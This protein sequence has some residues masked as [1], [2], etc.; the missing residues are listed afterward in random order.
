MR[1]PQEPFLIR[2]E[3]KEVAN[4]GLNLIRIPM[5]TGKVDTLE[6]KR[7]IEELAKNASQERYYVHG[8]GESDR[9]SLFINLVNRFHPVVKASITPD[10]ASNAITSAS[11]PVKPRIFPDK[12]GIKLERGTTIQVD[13]HVIVS[14]KPTLDELKEYFLNTPNQIVN[15]PVRTVVSLNQ[16]ENAAESREMIA[17]LKANHIAY[18]NMP[19]QLDPYDPEAV[20]KIVNKIK[21]LA[22]A[23]LVYS[24]YMPPQSTATAVFMTSWLTRLPA[25]PNN[26][27][28]SVPMQ[29]GEVKILAPNVA[30]GPRPNA[31]EFKDYLADKGIR[32]IAYVG[33]CEFE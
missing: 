22:N 13:N 7:Q 9:V 19:I 10:S 17:L 32:G 29:A 18:Y 31:A 6:G 23:V 30:M 21:S 20:L 16:D 33:P 4:L 11:S 8:F 26:L 14:P 27:F 2:K 28:T 3:E 1:L 5:L 24:Y 15:I 25:L 12:S